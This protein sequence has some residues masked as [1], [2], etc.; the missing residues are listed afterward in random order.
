MTRW[1]VLV[2]ALA[3]VMIAATA[4]ALQAER[5]PGAAAA[6]GVR[7]ALTPVLSARRV[8]E[9]I[10]APVADRRLV[11]HL[12]DLVSRTPGSSCLTVAVDGRTVF[13]SESTSPII[14]AS[15]EKLATAQAALSKL[16]P[17][18]V[19]TTSV[20]TGSPPHDGVVD[21][22]IWLVGGGDPLLMT[23]AY[24]EHFKHQPV[25]HTD[26]EALADRVVAAG[27]H[28]V[29]G[30]VVGDDSRYDRARVVPQWADEAITAH[31]IGPLGALVVN[32][33]L[34]QFPPTSDARTPRET[35]AVDPAT[36]AANQLTR[37]LQA[38]GVVVMGAPASGSAP[39][40]A[41]EVA[42]LE[43]PPID[44]VV[45]TMVRESDNEAAEL[46]TKEI[47]LHDTGAGT[48]ANG[49]A[50]IRQVFQDRNLPLDGVAQVD[51]SGLS[52]DDQ[53]T[54]AFVQALLDAEGPASTLAKDMPVAGQTGTLAERFVGTPI[55]GQLRAKTGTLNQVTALAGYVQTA[56]GAQM[57]FSYI[58]NLPPPKVI[59]SDD[60][61]LEDELGA[62][63][64]Q[65]PETPDINALGPKRG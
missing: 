27:V 31:D 19:L 57:S 11:A 1:R 20:K 22:D 43:S 17:N 21:G 10:A 28:E 25:T 12:N 8:P 55:V 16:D 41:T 38:R 6:T 40:D 14:P 56:R 37:L 62:I 63:L 58:I 60:V 18:A 54:C 4:I 52:R 45:A 7:T 49:I 50:G 13:S 29:R 34:T 39:R 46:L 44:Q 47:G 2:V 33:G 26:F 32:D 51:G 23:D 42:K 24:A 30:S 36:D 9:L 5:A 59:T 61:A 53:V 15:V 65:Y 35:A 3:V 64:F 48:T